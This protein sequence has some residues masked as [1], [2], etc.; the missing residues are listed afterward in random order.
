MQKYFETIFDVVYLVTVIIIGIVMIKRSKEKQY[1]IFGIMAII[2]GSGDAFHL[3][4]RAYA[5]NTVGLENLVGLL[6]IGKLVTSITMTVFYVLLYYVWV[7]RYKKPNNSKLTKI[8]FFLA[9]A[10]IILCVFQQN[11]WTSTNPSLLWGILRNIPFL[12]LGIII[13]VIYI[14]EIRLNKDMPFKFLP[15]SI[16]LSFIC[17]I[18]VVLFAHKYALVGILMIPKTC[19]YVWTVVIGYKAMRSTLK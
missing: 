2:L 19:A 10:R 7:C 4:P 15:L 18:P 11:G 16:I 17:Y 13:I 12:I 1:S 9:I 3:V 5:L 14:V 8:I 6:G